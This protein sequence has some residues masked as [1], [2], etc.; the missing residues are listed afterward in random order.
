MQSVN[1]TVHRTINHVNNLPKIKKIILIVMVII[2]ILFILDILNTYYNNKQNY[3]NINNNKKPSKVEKMDPD[4]IVNATED[5]KMLSFGELTI[6]PSKTNVTLY[7]ADWCGHCKQ[8]IS[9]TWNKFN[10]HYGNNSN[11]KINKIDCTNTKTQIQ[12]P[13]GKIIQGFP[14]VI[15]NYINADGE[16]IEEEYNGGRSFDV[17]SKYV[18]QVGVTAA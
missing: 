3:T 6:D 18:E 4:T 7:F 16:Y 17:F 14:T 10:E 5:N 1:E 13:A 8:F 9:S 11:I 2:I 15:L 12:T